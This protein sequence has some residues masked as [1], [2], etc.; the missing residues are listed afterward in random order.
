MYFKDK[1]FLKA[2]AVYQKVIEDGY[3]VDF[4]IEGLGNSDHAISRYEWFTYRWYDEQ[5]NAGKF[6]GNVFDAL[7][8][9]Y[10]HIRCTNVEA[11]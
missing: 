2:I 4:D 9:C 8:L 6:K 7:S 5:R 3:K 11:A 10:C 1:E